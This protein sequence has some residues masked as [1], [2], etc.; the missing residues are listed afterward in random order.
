MTF[1]NFLVIGAQRAGTTL[2]HR[3]LNAHPEV[4]LPP[5]RKEVHYFDWYYERGPLWYQNFFRDPCREHKAIGEVTPDYLFERD[6]PSRIRETLDSVRFLVILRNPVE[7]AYS[8]YLYCLRSFNEKRCADIFLKEE[9]EVLR[10]GLYYQQLSRYFEHFDKS[11]FLVLYF[12]ELLSD[13]AS[14][15][16]T[17]AE[18]LDLSSSWPHPEAMV[19]DPVNASLIPRFRG[20]FARAQRFGEMLTR[21]DM[22][23]AVRAARRIGIP[24]LLGAGGSQPSMLPSTRSWLEAYYREEICSL[25]ALLD[26]DLGIWRSQQQ[27]PDPERVGASECP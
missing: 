24:A 11:S 3:I 4:F 12:H 16:R 13:P 19:R 17:I 21:Q 5:Q 10:R 20:A 23:W 22:D 27:G 2:L 8:W 1:P 15:L 25:E 26:H 6:V 14:N 7:R 9:E 18:F